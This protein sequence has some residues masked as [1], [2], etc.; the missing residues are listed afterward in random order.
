MSVQAKEHVSHGFR[1]WVVENVN[2]PTCNA[3]H[4]AML[5]SENLDNYE[6]TGQVEY[7]LSLCED[8]WLELCG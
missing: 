7:E 2:C 8:C 6:E 5:G 1:C 3:V 4:D